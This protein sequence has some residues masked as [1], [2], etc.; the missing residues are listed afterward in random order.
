MNDLLLPAIQKSTGQDLDPYYNL[1]SLHLKGD[2]NTGR[3]YNAFS[4]ASSNNFRLTNNG[5]VRGS[6]FSPY[7]TSW[8]GFF[9]GNGDYLSIPNSAN[10]NTTGDFTIEGWA[11]LTSVSAYGGMFSM[12]A[13]TG[14]TNGASITF[15]NTGYIEF[16]VNP[17]GQSLTTPT[18]LN[19]WFHVALV[20]SGN[21]TNNCSCYLNGTRVAQFTSTSEANG[22]SN[23]AVI[24]RYY[25]NGSDVYWVTGY[26]SN[27]RYV[28]GTP[29]YSGATIT[30]PTAPLTAISGTQ[31]L[32]CHANRFIDR[33]GSAGTFAITRNGNT[34]ISSFSPFL[35]TDTIS[36]SAYYDG[37]GDGLAISTAQANLGFGTGDFSTEFWAYRT[38]SN[39]FIVVFQLNTY[40]TGL[41]VRTE[42]TTYNDSFYFV[43]NSYNW[44]PATNFPA[45][46]WT[47]I[48]ITRQ[49]STLRF[50]VNGKLIINATNTANMGAATADIGPA[51]YAGY[52]S[53]VRV[54]KG[55]VPVEYQTSVTTVGTQVFTPPTSLRTAVTNTQLLTLQE[56]GAYNT[57]G[58]EDESEYQHPITRNGNVAQGTFSPF[59]PGGWSN[60]FSATQCAWPSTL[61][62]D[63]SGISF[64]IECWL[65]PTAAGGIYGGLIIGC[66]VSGRA[67]SVWLSYSDTNKVGIV[68]AGSA[69]W[70]T[71]YSTGSVPL[72]TWT[73]VAITISGA[74]GSATA[75][76]Y[77][78]GVLDKTVNN[79]AT[80]I[81]AGINC[82][83]GTRGDGTQYN[84]TGHIS[85]L[86][87]TRNQILY[88]GNFTP[89]AAELIATSVGTTGANVAAS[90]TGTV[91]AIL[92]GSAMGRNKIG[93]VAPSSSASTI[94]TFAPFKPPAYD[95][96]VHG[97]SGYFDGTGDSLAVVSPQ[98][99]LGT[100]N[101]TAECWFYP[102]AA[103]NSST[104]LAC[105]IS[106]GAG[107]YFVWASTSNAFRILVHAG[108]AWNVDASSSALNLNTWNHLAMTRDGS[109]V[110]SFLNG[111]LASVTTGITGSM[112]ATAPIIRIGSDD[113][114]SGV[115]N[116]SYIT[117]VR[118]VKGVVYPTSSST[119]GI[120]IFTP[121]NQS[122]PVINNTLFL[123]NFTNGGVIDST[124]KN[125]IET[126]GNAGVV[127][128]A[129]KKYGSG[130]MFFDATADQQRV[131]PQG[132]AVLGNGDWTVEFW[133]Y[134]NATPAG[135]YCGRFV[136]PNTGFFIRN[137]SGTVI[138][139]G[140]NGSGVA[141]TSASGVAAANTWQ[142]I[143]LA[144]TGNTVNLYVNGICRGTTSSWT[145]NEYL[146]E[147]F[148][149]GST[150]TGSEYFNG[151]IDDFRVTRG[152][153]RY[154]GSTVGTTYFT[155]PT[156]AFPDRGTASTLTT[157]MAAPSSVEALVVGGGGGAGG[158]QG[159]GGGAGGFREFVGGNAIAVAG[160]TNY[161]ISIGV[162][163]AGGVSGAG[164]TSG[165]S[166]RPST[167]STITSAGGGGGGTVGTNG[168][169]GGSGGGGG[170]NSPG[171]SLGG[172]GNREA[173]TTTVVPTQGNNGGDSNPS[174]PNYYAGGGG[175]AGGAGQNGGSNNGNG[176]VAQTSSI[177]GATVY[178]AGGGGAGSR[179]GTAGLGGGTATT[180]NKGGGG[181]G[182]AS[183]VGSSA[184]ANTGGGGGGGA[185][186]Y[187][188][189]AGGSGVVILA[190]PTSFRPLK[191][192]LGL[193]Y[194]ID[195]VTRPGYRVYRFTSGSG[196]ISW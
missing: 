119:T 100:D 25:A 192:S 56:R 29:V 74:S 163:G 121:P 12:R 5:D 155:P 64:T 191:A 168:L 17:G 70:T 50:F 114:G 122:V 79:I 51:G 95:P 4:D 13:S 24:G 53:D 151:Y 159:G 150:Y 22:A 183:G 88:T 20:R 28:V 54:V 177:T 42:S 135:G 77:I 107:F 45:N 117:G 93:S 115:V 193:V 49:S 52:L 104:I 99:T 152:L 124:G 166:G 139:C 101:L 66:N 7:G 172:L 181:D 142:H 43:N 61:W 170:H 26:L 148:F 178:Y 87:I 158:Q 48:C 138:D 14:T 141:I 41:Y 37:T 128:T 190:Y 32:T 111:V 174:G 96:Q 136:Y 189:G 126:V 118:I 149:V 105:K 185:Y 127:T 89:P 123:L 3:N 112:G 19:Q 110:R 157:S 196:S 179:G 10:L 58:F 90:I 80:G 147:Y 98:F 86:R 91:S 55:S 8:S 175:G 85:N 195:T 116:A 129:I 184:L 137:A 30:V 145:W 109:T 21:A 82:I 176:G 161:P 47:H 103:G 120:Q 34:R 132:Q 84:Y 171:T 94:S 182:S 130:S 144:K 108:A 1:V 156:K 15:L 59:S 165:T 72:N 188:G 40:N 62:S 73:H 164:A 46:V 65:Y 146:S 125:V 106:G 36:G 167:F 133:A 76:I 102:T 33:D 35:E 31:V 97:G 186:A 154:T 68:T 134:A 143:A 67:D 75:K 140:F 39:S 18:P 169:N 78:D 63:L 194:T 131:T 83:S 180:A 60:F 27:V 6:N 162:G 71:F 44:D 160:S 187:D 23:G 2:V 153:A 173:G 57:I 69:N 81:P 38:N 16:A 9:D 113:A 92:Y 11:Y